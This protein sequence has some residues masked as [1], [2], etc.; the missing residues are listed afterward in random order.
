MLSVG[1]VTHAD[2]I[3]DRVLAV[4]M[5]RFLQVGV[6]Y[7][8]VLAT[9]GR[10]DSWDAWCRE[11]MTTAQMHEDLAERWLAGGDRSSA[12]EALQRASIY[13]HVAAFVF[14]RDVDLHNL[15]YQ[16]MISCYE[17][18]V[19]LSDGA[20]EK[21]TIPFEQAELKALLSKPAGVERPP[22]VVVIPGLDST[23]ETR[24]GARGMYLAR[25]LAVLSMDGPGQ[26]ELSLTTKIRPDYEAPVGAVLDYLQTRDDV[27]ASRVALSGASL[28][29]YYAPR[30]AA[31]DHR[32]RACIANCGPYRS[33]DN[34]EHKM[35]V[36][37]E[38]Y[39]H[40]LGA[41]DEEEA[42]E[43]VSRLTLED[44][45][46]HITCPL[47]IIQGKQD[48]LVDWRNAEMLYAAVAGPKELHLF[49]EGNH[50]CQNIP[51]KITPLQLGFLEKHLAPAE[52]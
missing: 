46:E 1:R 19:S 50:S 38:A 40:Y 41:G 22:V 23:K 35:V 33:K 32:V 31:F 28:G 30:A 47:M 20:I 11:W 49:E 39:Q 9:A 25:G 2:P 4:W 51:Y 24:H 17:R 37:R 48:P 34:W 29:G 5:P 15:G 21:L 12:R 26:G 45:A 10:I 36:T 16:K 6:L 13:Y 8:D 14:F 43:L 7:G 27:D 52:R 44:C 18:A 3:V 42:K